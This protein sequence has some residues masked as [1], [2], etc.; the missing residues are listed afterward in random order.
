MVAMKDLPYYNFF[1]RYLA[2]AILIPFTEQVNFVVAA[3]EAVC[4]G[5]KK[6]HFALPT[7]LEIGSM[8]VNADMD[9]LNDVK[10]KC[11]N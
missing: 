2:R 10:K 3:R 8:L 5:F 4:Q 6:A 7:L 1:C 9:E 11:W